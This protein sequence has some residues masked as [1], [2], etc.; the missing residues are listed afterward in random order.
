MGYKKGLRNNKLFEIKPY[1]VF[2]VTTIIIYLILSTSV[3][4]KKYDLQVGEIAKYDIKAPKDVEDKIATEKLKQEQLNHIQESYTYDS[5]IKKEALENID[6]LFSLVNNINKN[7]SSSVNS[8]DDAET[9]KEK[10]EKLKEEKLNKLKEGSP[11]NSLSQENYETLIALTSSQGT[12]LLEDLKACMSDMYDTVTIYEGNTGNL[13]TAQWQITNHFNNSDYDKSVKELAIAIGQSQTKATYFVDE[14]KTTEAKENAV[15]GVSPV[16]YKKDQTIV[17]EGQPVTEAQLA[18]LGDLGLLNTKDSTD[19][20]LHIA[21][22]FIIVMVLVIQWR[23]ISVK[24]KDIYVDSSKIILVNMLT[25]IMVLLARASMMISPYIMPFACVSILMAVLFD[26]RISVV[27]GALNVIFISFVVNFSSDVILIALLNSIVVPI[28][29]RRVQQRNDILYS[30][31]AIGFV[32]IIFTGV[33]GYFLSADLSSILMK[34]L[35]TG[36]ASLLSG[37]LA[38]GILPILENLFDIVTNMKLLE[39]SNPNHPLMRRLLLEAPGTYHHS[40]LVANLAE[41]A[42]EKVGANPIM[43]R[44]AAYYHDVG[45]LERPYYFK[46]NQVGGVNPHDKM[47]PALSAAIILSHVDDGVK[48]ANKYNLPN[49]IIDVIREHHGDSLAKYFYIT[50]R[51]KSENPDEIDEKDYKYSGPPPTSRESSIVMMAD[52]VEASV[53][54]IQN[55]TNEKIEEMV[56]NIIKARIDE[57][58][59]INSELTFKDIEKIKQS[60]LK[61]LSGIYHERIE[62][63][64]DKIELD[65]NGSKT[66]L[67]SSSQSQGKDED[68][69]IYNKRSARKE[70]VRNK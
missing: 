5:N 43:A 40:V 59:L 49:D 36:A 68:I 7:T 64:K 2:I 53:R 6:K 19:I 60:F 12:I 26:D 57:K 42:A 45:K 55:P 27:I 56:N 29:M 11:I 25:V 37:I 31:I 14:E 33:M 1:I 69:K 18:I 70:A 8:D 61:V 58:Q 38:I 30:S 21:L 67:A 4:G 51:N 44:V 48:L 50:M 22:L 15:K 23:Y 35:V 13:V 3:V 46:E 41:M 28:I 16:I 20:Y 63:P 54:S 34:A 66:I 32:N 17:A 52:G 39:L 65:K 10:E 24:R 47:S 62:Y 9:V